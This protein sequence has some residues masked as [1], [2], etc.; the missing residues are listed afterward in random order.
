MGLKTFSSLQITLRSMSQIVLPDVYVPGARTDADRTVHV[1]DFAVQA[2]LGTVAPSATKEPVEILAREIVIPGG[3]TI[4]LDLSDA[5]IVGA[6]DTGAPAASEDLTGLTLLYMEL[7]TA[8]GNTGAL[9][10]APAAAN[11]YKLF[12]TGADDGVVLPKGAHLA[13]Y[14]AV[15]LLPT[16]GAAAKLVT[17]SGTVGDIANVVMVF[18]T[19]PP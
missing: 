12:G 15:G 8:D 9:T 11:G 1:N 2:S 19:P 18:D 16:I 4:D 13:L 6:I 17:F 10:I 5:P 3:G 14:N 7:H